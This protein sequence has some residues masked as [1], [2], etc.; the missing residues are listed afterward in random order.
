MLE[1]T[2]DANASWSPL[3]ARCTSSAC[4]VGSGIRA[5]GL[6]AS[7]SMEPARQRT[8]IGHRQQRMSKG[9]PAIGGRK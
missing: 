4:I 8:F 2:S 5:A 6:A 1:D 3:L 9:R 7:P